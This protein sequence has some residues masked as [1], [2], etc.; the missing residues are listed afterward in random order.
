[1]KMLSMFT[2]LTPLKT[3]LVP[4]IISMTVVATSGDAKISLSV[5]GYILRSIQ[6][7]MVNTET[8][9]GKACRS[10][11]FLD[12]KVGIELKDGRIHP[13][14]NSRSGTRSTCHPILSRGIRKC[15]S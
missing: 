12:P 11:E 13:G 2:A 8:W 10:C 6:H 1:M 7:F 14:C 4:S 15:Q 5:R 9:V 3:N